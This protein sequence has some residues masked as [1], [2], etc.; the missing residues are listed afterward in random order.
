MM[1]DNKYIE[2]LRKLV[3]DFLAAYNV[4]VYLYGSYAKG[5]AHKTSDVDIAILPKGKIPKDLFSRLREAIEES[6]IPYNVDV[7]D[8]TQVSDEF[9]RQILKDAIL[10]KDYN[11][12]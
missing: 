3:I 7:T 12:E 11:K 2:Q 9:R 5:T 4:R 1:A 8:L 6:T 10:W